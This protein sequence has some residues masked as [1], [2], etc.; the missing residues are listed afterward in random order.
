MSHMTMRLG[1]QF[2]VTT[3][4]TGRMLHASE[5]GGQVTWLKKTLSYAISVIWKYSYLQNPILNSH[6]ASMLFDFALNV[7]RRI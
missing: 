3:A 5:M 2:N 7:K 6:Y 4:K 1:S